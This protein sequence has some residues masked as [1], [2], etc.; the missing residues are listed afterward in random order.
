MKGKSKRK[1]CPYLDINGGCNAT[2]SI[3]TKRGNCPMF[4]RTNVN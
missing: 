1:M 3:Y 4:W 2:E